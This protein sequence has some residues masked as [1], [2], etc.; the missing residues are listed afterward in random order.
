MREL[1]KKMNPKT[2]LSHLKYRPDIDGLR[3]IAVLAV[4]LFHAFP[5]SL[6]GGFIGVDIFFV[7][8]GFLISAII[9]EN[10]KNKTFSF[11]DFYSRRVRR[12]FPA[13]LVVISVTFGFGF[14]ILSADE[15]NQL[16]KLIASGIGFV[17][18]LVLWSES[19]YFDV[20]TETKPLLH[21]WS[22]GIEEQFYII[23]PLLLIFAWNKKI[24]L[25]FVIILILI[26]SFALNVSNIKTDPIG[27]FYSP[28]TRIWELLFGSLLAWIMVFK[29]NSFFNITSKINNLLLKVKIFNNV[30]E[31]YLLSNIFSCIGIFLFII[32]FVCITKES[33]FPGF[34]ALIPVLGTVLVIM[35]GPQAWINE[36][37]LS[38]KIAVWFGLISFPLYLWHWPLLSYGRIYYD[39]MPP[40]GFRWVAVLLSILLAWLTVKYIEKPFRYSKYQTRT[41]VIFLGSVAFFIATLGLITYTTNFAESKNFKDFKITRKGF[42][43]AYGPSINWYQGKENWLFLGNSYDRSVEK[44]KL[45]NT[46]DLQD[47]ENISLKMQEIV[48]VANKFNVQ[49]VFMMGPNKESIYPEF[50]P[51]TLIP[52]DKKYSSYFLNAFRKIPQLNIYDPTFDL[53]HAKESEGLL[54]WK[55]DTHWNQKGAYIAFN[56][57]VKDLSIPS[58]KVEFKQGPI[59]EGDLIGIS[60]LEKFPVGKFDNWVLSWD[61]EAISIE[62]ILPDEHESSFGHPKIVTTSNALTNKYIWVVGDSFSHSLIPYLNA[63]FKHVKYVGHWVD[64]LDNLPK[65]LAKADKKPDIILIERVERSF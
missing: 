22:L 30:D 16:G 11:R 47:I 37:I 27:T 52:S 7:I 20:A 24:N 17:A 60:K 34:W 65:E 42:E 6:R 41:K 3:A 29:K 64:K 1:K 23:W 21:L 50:L 15:F 48:N 5:S 25:F 28:L 45:V 58:P 38:N 32:G 9:Y 62:K 57:L 55:T 31:K 56:G 36:K 33:I 2:N 40:S 53:K 26:L 14:F 4:V 51:T 59:Y 54:Y 19:G 46:P 61:K 39:K 49:V 35:A 13:L 10:V 63:T 18:N 43:Y 12:I 8:S 44:L